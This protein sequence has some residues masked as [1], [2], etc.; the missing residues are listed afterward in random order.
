V[1]AADKMNS[2]NDINTGNCTFNNAR[3]DA[4]TTLNLSGAVFAAEEMSSGGTINTA[5][6][7][8]ENANLALLESLDLS[9][10]VVGADEMSSSGNNFCSE[11]FKDATFTNGKFEFIYLPKEFVYGN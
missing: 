4:L 5:N 3:F 9:A 7:M 10:I 1:F 6:K 8:F 11:T 2:E